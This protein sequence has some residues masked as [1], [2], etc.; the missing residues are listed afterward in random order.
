M[1][2]GIYCDRCKRWHTARIP[3]DSKRIFCRCG[4][5]WNVGKRV[6]THGI[7]F[8]GKLQLLKRKVLHDHRTDKKI[9]DRY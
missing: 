9:Y 1:I 8:K 2:L 5:N 7:D 4:A 3:N 6:W